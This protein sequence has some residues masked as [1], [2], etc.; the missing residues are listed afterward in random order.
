MSK[1]YLK[2]KKLS[3]FNFVTLFVSVLLGLLAIS[4]T[5]LVARVRGQVPPPPVPCNEQRPSIWPPSNWF[6]HEFQSLRPYQASPCNPNISETTISCGN[7]LIAAKKYKVGPSKAKNCVTNPDDGKQTCEFE[8]KN[9]SVNVNISLPDAELPILGNTELTENSQLDKDKITDAQ[10]VNEYVSWYLNGVNGR[11]EGEYLNPNKNPED[12][13]KIINLSGPLKKLLPQRIQNE[14]RRKV[15]EAAEKSRQNKEDTQHNQIV[16]CTILGVPVPCYHKA[17]GLF[18][19]IDAEHRL[20]D[21]KGN[22]TNLPTLPGTYNKALPPKEEDYKSF[23]DYWKAYNEWRGNSC[24]KFNIPV[25]N[26]E[27]VL[28]SPIDNPLRPNF[29]SNLYSYIPLSLTEDR[30]GEAVAD[31]SQTEQPGS[32]EVTVSEV[33]FE[34]SQNQNLLFSP[35]T[36][37]TAKLASLL[38]ST[39]APKDAKTFSGSTGENG[40]FNTKRCEKTDVRSNPGDKLFG[41]STTANSKPITGTIKYAAKFS[42]TFD[43]PVTDQTCYDDCVNSGTYPVEC[44]DRCTPER[45]CEKEANVALSVYSKNPKINE[46]YERTVSGDQSVYKR[47]FPKDLTSLAQDIPAITKA[48]YSSDADKTF[49]GDPKNDRPGDQAQLFIPHLGSVY[50]YFLKGIQIALRPRGF[51]EFVSGVSNLLFN[52]QINCNQNA[53][54]VSLNGVLGKEDFT[55]FALNHAGGPGTHAK[56]C[57]NDVI[58]KSKATGINPA[59]SL[60]IWLWESDASNYSMSV[61]DFG[62]H[63]GFVRGFNDQFN[64]FLERV[65][66]YESRFPECF[67]SLPYMEAFLRIYNGGNCTNEKGLQYYTDVKSYWPL[68]APGCPFPKT[69]KDTSCP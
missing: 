61:E 8:F 19:L 45:T 57:Y 53:P 23:T 12:A 24:G 4:S 69:P 62:V 34:S 36:E 27:I 55:Q 66:T 38:Q 52:V 60:L 1:P 47:M 32:G 37:E 31:L 21:W 63:T 14:E 7:D 39:Y 22:I 43:P 13:S 44:V 9:E 68:V 49:A 10:K 6:E 67:K 17:G 29:W 59:L 33:K 65:N 11:A 54:D 64:G 35:H 42:C 46:I 56:E 3:R 30:K 2:T 20:A 48:N 50:D 28:C 58:L 51:G 41:Q 15:V 5:L 25:L 40:F 26:K 16:A 18:D